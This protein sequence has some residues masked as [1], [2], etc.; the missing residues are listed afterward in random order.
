MQTMM[1]IKMDSSLKTQAQGVAASLGLPLS[2]V[3]NNYLR[4]FVD[5][6]RVVFT[7]HPIP[8]KQTAEILKLATRDIKVG[9]N[10][11]R[12]NSNKEM[13]DFLLAI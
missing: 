4:S 10:I 1:S 3:I 6:Q 13:D 5:T 12:F 2:T 9:K 7:N 11:K 8:N